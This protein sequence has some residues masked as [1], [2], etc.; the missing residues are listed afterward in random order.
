MYVET[1]VPTL[2]CSE[3]APAMVPNCQAMEVLPFESVVVAASDAIPPLN[4]VH[5][6]VTPLTGAPVASSTWTLTPPGMPVATGATRFAASVVLMML[7]ATGAA[8]AAGVFLLQAERPD[9][10][11]QATSA[12]RVAMRDPVVSIGGLL[13]RE[14]WTRQVTSS[15]SRRRLMANC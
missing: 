12:K 4:A 11:V 7:A 9:V 5:E 14:C 13:K 1:V 8:G 15:S 10:T 6:T 2:A 3:S